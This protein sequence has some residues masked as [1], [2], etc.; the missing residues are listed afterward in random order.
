M[1][2]ITDW[3]KGTI[4]SDVTDAYTNFVPNRTD[5][6]QNV[7]AHITNFSYRGLVNFSGGSLLQCI[8]VTAV[9]MYMI[10][11]KFLRAITWSLLAAVFALFGLID[12]PGVEVFTHT[13]DD[14]WKFSV[15]YT[16]ITV[17]FACFEIGQRRQWIKQAETEP[18]DLSAN[19]FSRERLPDDNNTD[20]T[21]V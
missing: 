16:M 7:S 1:P 9:F 5:F 3:A 11:R 18:D 14:G 20:E 12:A 2:I 4:I 6:N 8:F 19:E 10:D 21:N 15:G 13:N 17:L